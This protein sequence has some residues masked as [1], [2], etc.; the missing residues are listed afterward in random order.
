VL[1]YFIQPYKREKM[2]KKII[3]TCTALI[4]SLSTFAKDYNASFFGIK[5]DGVTLNTASIQYAID[6]ISKNGGGQL[7]FYVGRYLTGSFHLKPNVTIKLYEGAVL[8]AFQSIYDYFYINNTPALIL[9]E[10]VENIGIIG[11]GVIEGNGQS[12]LNSLTEQVEKGFL[13]ASE[14]QNKPALI[15]FNG[16]SNVKLEGIILRNAC[17]D[18]QNYSDCKGVNISNVTIESKAVSGSRGVVIT[19]CQGVNLEKSYI[20]TDGKEVNIDRASK[21]VSV[22]ET[23]NPKGKKL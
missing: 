7:N 21:S 18:T 17:G 3:I 11:K 19:N 16:C 22:K 1:L 2:S 5:S 9:A 20:D 13:P 23:I 6:Y 8:V 15:Y 4:L 14:L 10:N 12:V